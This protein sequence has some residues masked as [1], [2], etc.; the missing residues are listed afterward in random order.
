MTLRQDDFLDKDDFDGIYSWNEKKELSARKIFE[1]SLIW[2]V[3]LIVLLILGFANSYYSC[4]PANSRKK[5]GFAVIAENLRQPLSTRYLEGPKYAL[6][7]TVLPSSSLSPLKT[8]VQ[9]GSG[10]YSR[11][12]SGTRVSNQI[13]FIKIKVVIK[14]TDP[15]RSDAC[16]IGDI[17]KPVSKGIRW[18]TNKRHMEELNRLHIDLENP[19]KSL[20]KTDK[21]VATFKKI[22]KSLTNNTFNPFGELGV[23][24][25]AFQ[26]YC[27][28]YKDVDSSY[29][30]TEEQMNLFK[31]ESYGLA[32]LLRGKWRKVDAGGNQLKHFS[33]SFQRDQADFKTSE[34]SS[35]WA[36]AW[37]KSFDKVKENTAQQIETL[38]SQL[39]KRISLL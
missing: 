35:E 7:E 15:V 31:E 17:I 16:N 26:Q 24:D 39:Y 18:F 25:Y 1:S 27:N 23:L 21:V 34:W 22:I 30:F 5:P 29:L 36:R 28:Q 2:F 9:S 33:L 4:L 10:Q 6:G 14:T 13:K 3:Y 32:A 20:I 38:P 37:Q 12:L 11:S 19:E 8:G